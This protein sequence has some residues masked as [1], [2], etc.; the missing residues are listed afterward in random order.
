[1][2]LFEK[3]R[4]GN[5]EIKNRVVMA[6]MAVTIDPDGSLSERTVR[7]YEERA[8]GGVG[9][10]ITGYSSES[11]KYERSSCHKLDDFKK[12]S[13]VNDLVQRAHAY[14]T[15]VCIQLGP[16]LGRIVYI[17]PN[18]PP[19]SASDVESYWTKG[20][21]CIPLTKDDIK[22]IVR[23]IAFSASL[24]K[25]AGADAVELRTYGGYLADQFMSSLWN[26]RTDE[27]GGDLKGRMRF[28]L[29]M[30]EAI[31]NV[32][33]K[34]FPLI[35][36]YNPYHAIPGGRELPEGLE[37]AKMLEAAGVHALHL[38]KGCYDCWYNAITTVYQPDA[39][40]IELAAAVKQVVN[41]P[42]IAQGKLQNPTVAEQVL[43]EGKTDFVGLGHQMIADPHWTNKVKAGKIQQIIPCI[44]CNQCLK[45]HFDGKFGNCSVNPMTCYE[46]IYKIVPTDCS[47]NLLVVGGGPGG[48]EAALIASERGHK[49]TLWEKE[50]Q[51]G[52]LLLAAGA[53]DFK[54]PIKN[55]VKYLTRR[56]ESSD[57]DVRL[58]EEATAEEILAGGFDQVII[59]TGA[60]SLVPPVAGIDGENV[61]SSTDILLGNARVDSDHVV[62]VGGGL[63]GCETAV[64]LAQQGKDVTIVEMLADILATA[65]HCDNNDQCLRKM[66]SDSNV[67]IHAGTKVTAIHNDGIDIEKGGNKSSIP[68]G[69][70]VLACGYKPNNELAKQL[71]D[72]IDIKIIGD[73]ASPRKI[74]DAVQE[75]F[76]AGRLLD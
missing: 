17:D 75:G 29:E 49:V 12:I 9:M 46:D 31:Q 74:I 45:Y 62:V 38:D 41:I 18:T 64:F 11:E 4:I 34:D 65:D 66:I 27:Y 60:R 47:K 71:E 30:V 44:G 42:V 52:G 39:H 2:K 19:Y 15:K 76:H 69:G 70:V 14:G 28:T 36:K 23:L 43:A 20:M 10:I 63:V 7:Y 22:E 37:I 48:M 68:C 21:K 33:G 13:R 67:K 1:M 35:I 53:P 59:A 61:Y 72:V 55:Y 40:Q 56:I 6:P 16:G 5:L 26:K 32:C 25:R 57:V 50:D 58:M 24:A 54:E 8:K 51:L 3:G 73:S